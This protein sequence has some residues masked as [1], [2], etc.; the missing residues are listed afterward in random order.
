MLREA[1]KL[2]TR[3]RNGLAL[4]RA[5][6]TDLLPVDRGELEALARLLGMT[7]GSA[8]DL[9][10]HYLAATRR[11]RRVFDRRLYEE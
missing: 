2:A 8:R 9:E 5:R 11:A 10:E 6:S 1:W 7:A 4:A 3:I